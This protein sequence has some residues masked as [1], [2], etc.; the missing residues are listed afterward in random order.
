[1]LIIGIV[2]IGIIALLIDRTLL[3]G[4]LIYRRYGNVER[5]LYRFTPKWEN[6]SAVFG[7]IF[8]QEF[9]LLF[10]SPLYFF[11]LIGIPYLL[12]R[13]RR[14]ALVITL[15][16]LIY[17]LAVI[18][19]QTHSWYGGWSLP[20]RY[21]VVITPLIGFIAGI[22]LGERRG[23]ITVIIIRSLWIWSIS[24]VFILSLVTLWRY[25]L[26]NGASIL[27]RQIED[28]FSTRIV[29]FFPSFIS[30]SQEGLILFIVLLI[31]LIMSSLLIL[32]QKPL[33]IS[34]NLASS[35][36]IASRKR[37]NL[38]VMI[39]SGLKSFVGAIVFFLLLG[40]LII[41]LGRSLP[42]KKLEAENMR[43]KAGI[44]YHDRTKNV[45][46]LREKGVI[47]DYVILPKNKSA[48]INILAAGQCNTGK[49]PHMV[50]SIGE[51]VIG[52][53]D[54]IY[55]KDSWQSSNYIFEAPS[56]NRGMHL[57]S[58]EL[59]NGLYDPRNRRYCNLYVDRIEFRR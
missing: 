10:Y 21:L 35:S 30:P 33:S 16:I 7:L 27:L 53:T 25:N 54:I 39:N 44:Q 47:W 14:E 2:G 58:I 50:V 34:P 24:I 1:V 43:H 17:T 40:G 46:V 31:F 22:I 8:D 59:A 41:I 48:F 55:G 29:R 12:Y 52:D 32:K 4:L 5:I 37:S 13:Y 23:L 11:G 56:M 19:Y 9:G 45:W 28:L 18:G 51:K 57:F 6:I 38:T 15:P 42:T 36:V 26:A 3:D 20:S 49:A